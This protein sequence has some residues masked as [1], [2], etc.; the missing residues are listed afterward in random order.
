MS[1][2]HIVDGQTNRIIAHISYQNLI[3]N[4]HKQ[5]LKD[6]LETFKFITFADQTYSRHLAKRNKVII[7]G[8]DGEFREFT[9]FEAWKYRSRSWLQAEVYTKASYLDLKKAKIIFPETLLGQTATTATNHA[10]DGTVWEPG[11][12]TFADTMKIVIEEHTDP[13]SFLKRIASEFDLELKFRIEVKDGRIV[14]RYVDMIEKVGSWRGRTAEFGKDLLSLRRIEKTDQVVTALL[15]LGPVRS[16]GTRLEVLIEDTDALTRWGDLNED[17]SLRHLIEIYEPQSSDEDMTI[18]RLR[19]LTENELEK[20]IN[21]AVE[22][23]G[24]IADLEHIPGNQNKKIRFGDTI[25]IKDIKF[26]PPLYLE[27]RIHTQ[28]RDIVQ[29]ANKQVTLGDYIE[30]SEE[31]V[32]AIWKSL[33]DQIREKAS[34]GEVQAINEYINT[35]EDQWSKFLYTWIMFA[36]NETGQN[37]SNDPI[38]KNYMGIAYNKETDIPSTDPIVYSWTKIKGEQ[39]IPGAPGEDGQPTYTWLKYA[40]NANGLKMSDV[41]TGKPYLGVAHNKTTAVESNEPTDYK[42]SLIKGE[43]GE[44]GPQGPQGLQGIQGSKGDEGIPGPAGADG[45]TSYTHIAYADSEDGS[46][47][48]S[49][50]DST[51]K[52]YI[53][54]YTDFVEAD[55][56]NPADYKWTLIKGAD[57][58]QGIPGQAGANGRTPYFHTAWATNAT[59]TSGFSTTSASGKT[60]IG[61]YTD[62]TSADSTDPSKYTW[63][64]IQGPKGDTGAQGP[65]GPKGDTGN[66]GPTGPQGPQGPNIVDDATTFGAEFAT[67]G[68]N[69]YYHGLLPAASTGGWFRIAKNTGSRAFGRFILKDTTSGYHQTTTFEASI[70]YGQEPF[71]AVTSSSSYGSPVFTA[72]RIVH[73]STYDEAYLEVYVGT[74]NRDISAH[75]WLTD[76]IQEAGWIGLD[77]T[78]GGVP[79]AGD[80]SGAAYSTYQRTCSY[81]NTMQDIADNAKGTTDLWRYGNTTF[82]NGG[83]I[84]TNSVTANQIAVSVLSALTANLGTVTAGS[85][86]SNTFIDVTT[87]LRVG[88][89]IYLGNQASLS[90][91][92]INFNSTAKISSSNNDLIISASDIYLSPWVHFGSAAGVSHVYYDPNSR[93]FKTSEKETG[94]CGLGGP[95]NGI[96]GVVLLETVNFRIKKTYV[97]SS[98]SYTTITNNRTPKFTDIT[99]DGFSIYIE[100]EGSTG[101]FIHWRGKYTA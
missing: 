77:W 88:D 39:G 97:P 3:S 87:D 75:F 64:L 98:I 16:D 36:D 70:H 74:K 84:Y 33:Q 43:K 8:E 31:E 81:G 24:G 41:P 83:Q 42:W 62:F 47:N 80:K 22:Y 35:N 13:F 61:T 76:N 60:Y 101:A 90:N 71:I 100:G 52:L 51:N 46:V 59:G 67:L 79:V 7:P 56:I 26:E 96:S 40:D 99:E 91:K 85:L 78:A 82:I 89:D 69:Y 6:S 50:S 95:P 2:V 66:T 86:T 4:K 93:C 27:A 28:E 29:E 12:I 73:A 65:V 20:R 38:G 54:M 94:Q 14:G 34:S 68:N 48:F 17:G 21:A 57:G 23:E 18:D 58:E 37:M 49:V 9:I 5:S 44:S 55:S 92:Q 19:T 1:L 45:K 30:Y 11:D 15:G 25:R 53:G 32:K 63:A 72:V 10:L